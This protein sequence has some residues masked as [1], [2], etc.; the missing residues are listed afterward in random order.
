MPV[1]LKEGFK[2]LPKESPV[3]RTPRRPD[4]VIQENDTE[5]KPKTIEPTPSMPEVKKMPRN[6]NKSPRLTNSGNYSYEK[7]SLPLQ[8]QPK[9]QATPK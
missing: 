2:G 7:A 5:R 9:Y 1:G 4:I 6:G 8:A 3:S